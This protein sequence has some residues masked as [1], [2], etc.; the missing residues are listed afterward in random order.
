MINIAVVGA[1][2]DYRTA[3]AGIEQGNSAQDQGAHGERGPQTTILTPGNYRLNTYLWDLTIYSAVDVAEGSVGVVKSNVIDSVHFGSLVAD[4]PS[5]CAQK[6]VSTNA[7]GEATGGRI[8]PSLRRARVWR[9][10]ERH[11]F[12]HDAPATAI[13]LFWRSSG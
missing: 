2:D 7:S 9:A 3:G 13:D 5:S 12:R 4:K 8:P 10:V 1:A 6:K 11:V